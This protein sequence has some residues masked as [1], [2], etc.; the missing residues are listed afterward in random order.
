MA[1]NVYWGAVSE[2][3]LLHSLEGNPRLFG[4]K[5]V[6]ERSLKLFAADRK[7]QNKEPRPLQ[8]LPYKI[9][10]ANSTTTDSR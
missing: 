3:G 5:I 8:L 2:D 10:R 9:I 1:E 4:D 6:A 7:K